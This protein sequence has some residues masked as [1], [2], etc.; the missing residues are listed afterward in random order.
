MNKTTKRVQEIL[1]RMTCHL[2]RIIENMVTK[3][4]IGGI[5]KKL[6]EV[7]RVIKKIDEENTLGAH[8]TTR[9]EKRVDEHDRQIAKLRPRTA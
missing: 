1:D 5:Q 4:D 2:D 6:D 9:L 3:E 8:R 7:V